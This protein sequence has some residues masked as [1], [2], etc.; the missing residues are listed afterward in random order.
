M[1]V[2]WSYIKTIGAGIGWVQT[3]FAKPWSSGSIPARAS[4]FRPLHNQR[5]GSPGHRYQ[6][7]ESLGKWFVRRRGAVCAGFV[8]GV[9]FPRREPDPQEGEVARL[10]KLVLHHHAEQV[11]AKVALDSTREK[12]IAAQKK[13]SHMKRHPQEADQ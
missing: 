8:Q 13:L 3:R 4:I 5:I 6:L 9:R 11:N 12:L 1:T 10:N 7:G 2:G